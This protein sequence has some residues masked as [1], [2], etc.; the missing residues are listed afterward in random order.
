MAFA[1][2]QK[3]DTGSG[4]AVWTELNTSKSF[5]R[6]WT[7]LDIAEHSCV[8]Q[9]L[10]SCKRV[11]LISLTVITNRVIGNS[12]VCGFNERKSSE[13]FGAL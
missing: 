12:E 7:V 13:F 4:C 3:F 8:Q 1:E 9:S 6:L 2:T 10:C 11:K 5:G